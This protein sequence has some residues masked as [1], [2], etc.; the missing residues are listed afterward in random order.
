MVLVFGTQI[1]EFQNPFVSFLFCDLIGLVILKNSSRIGEEQFISM[2]LCAV[3]Y[4]I[5]GQV[6]VLS[7]FC[8]FFAIFLFQETMG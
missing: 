7:K 4:V 8:W 6:K 1:V 5:L 2:E 3:I